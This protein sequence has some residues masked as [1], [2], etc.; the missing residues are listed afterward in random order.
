MAINLKK[1]EPSLI[2]FCENS[3]S[4]SKM[5]F[6]AILYE[7]I[8]SKRDYLDMNGCTKWNSPNFEKVSQIIKAMA[9]Y[10]M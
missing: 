8:N 6:S 2:R 9:N 7:E 5:I 3:V 4:F 10:R 1:F